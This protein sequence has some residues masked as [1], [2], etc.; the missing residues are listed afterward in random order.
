MAEGILRSII[1]DNFNVQSAGANPSGKVNPL[2][3]QVMQEIGIDISSHSSK[4]LN[5][6]L[7]KRVNTVITVCC[8]ASQA[9]PTF[10]GQM[11]RH[12]WQ[13]EDPSETQGSTEEILSSFREIRD[14]VKMVFTAYA[15]GL[16][17]GQNL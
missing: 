6:F 9:C 7:D 8:N 17:D 10:P 3:I 5:N 12:H 16:I 1:G 14:Q 11:K 15:Q 2:T 13:F 4:H